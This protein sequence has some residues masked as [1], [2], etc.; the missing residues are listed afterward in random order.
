[1][2]VADFV[3]RGDLVGGETPGLGKNRVHQV[4]AQIAEPLRLEG[5]AQPC[6]GFECVSNFVY[7]RTIHVISSLL[8]A[9][10]SWRDPAHVHG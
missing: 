1:M 5:L 8:P 3:E 4:F 7:R 6:D 2:L 9:R 10:P